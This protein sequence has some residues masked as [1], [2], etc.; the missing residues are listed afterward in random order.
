[1]DMVS[2]KKEKGTNDK[3]DGNL[4]SPPIFQVSG[5]VMVSGKIMSVENSGVEMNAESGERMTKEDGRYWCCK[6]KEGL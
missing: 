3:V 4:K 2:G 5:K 1:M 6:V